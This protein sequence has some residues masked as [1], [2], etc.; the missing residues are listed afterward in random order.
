[1]KEQILSRFKKSDAKSE[2]V[3]P[4]DE[5]LAPE[6]DSRCEA[7]LLCKMLDTFQEE[8]KEETDQKS[9][10]AKISQDEEKEKTNEPANK[11]AKTE[12]GEPA[13]PFAQLEKPPSLDETEIPA[14]CTL[15]AYQGNASPYVIGS[16]P[17]GHK[18]KGKATCCRSFNPNADVGSNPNASSSKARQPGRAAMTE[19]A[20]RA[21][22]AAWLW[23]WAKA[24]NADK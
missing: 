14:G 3:S 9:K 1:M 24:H 2:S 17:A 11:K 6:L 7:E 8:E 4:D 12:N 10:K 18:W 22:V 16:L 5:R 21:A 19:A 20:A 15:R 13:V 23:D